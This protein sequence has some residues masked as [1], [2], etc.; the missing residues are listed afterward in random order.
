MSNSH[1]N[2]VPSEERN[3][4]AF[5]E[6]IKRNDEAK[7]LAI[8]RNA[9]PNEIYHGSTLLL[10][11]MA[12]GK[13]NVV[14]EM[15]RHDPSISTMQEVLDQMYMQHK[16]PVHDQIKEMVMNKMPHIN[17][18]IGTEII[19]MRVMY[20][21][22]LMDVKIKL[23]K[24]HKKRTRGKFKFKNRLLKDDRRT[25]EQCGI[26][27]G[28]TVMIELHGV[29]RRERK[30]MRVR[31]QESVVKEMLA[32]CFRVKEEWTTTDLVRVTKQPRGWLTE[33]LNKIAVKTR[34][35]KWKLKLANEENRSDQ[36]ERMGAMPCLGTAS[37]K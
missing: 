2:G 35:K 25:L 17:V 13:P 11:A 26:C 9:D 14:E 27:T 12:D 33:I 32:K 6:A 4:R 21:D 31:E 37:L 10:W 23:K 16:Q 24:K 30:A 18:K 19:R 5:V 28:D 22:R 36:R 3:D 34:K 1:P 8:A 20:S 7:M 29:R 15:L